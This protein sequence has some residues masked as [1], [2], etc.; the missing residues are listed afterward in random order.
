MEKIIKKRYWACVF[1]P[2]SLPIDWKDILQYKGLQV[3]ISPLHDKDV[4][5]DNTIKKAHYH[6]ILCF[7]G[8]TT[9][10]SVNSICEELNQ[11]IPKPLESVRGYYRYFTHMDNPEKYQYDPHL[12][13][14]INGFD[15]SNFAELTT[16]E[17]LSIK[18]AIINLIRDNNFVEYSDLVN[19]VFDNEDML[20]RNFVDVV[21]NHTIYFNTYLTSVRHKALKK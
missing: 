10:K 16:S 18:K 8:P 15:I 21:S 14:T 7:E 17:I 2:D 20:G 4:N 13:S 19:F 11:P 12:I 3:A 5:P 6:L 1:Y 9:F